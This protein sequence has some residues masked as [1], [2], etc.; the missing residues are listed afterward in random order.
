MK[1]TADMFPGRFEIR[2][3]NGFFRSVVTAGDAEALSGH[4]ERAAGDR[5]PDPFWFEDGRVTIGAR[6]ILHVEFLGRA[7]IPPSRRPTA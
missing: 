6:V 4:V 7:S 1:I 5:E 3:A 2:S